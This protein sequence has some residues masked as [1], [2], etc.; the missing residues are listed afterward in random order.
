MAIQITKRIYLPTPTE[1]IRWISRAMLLNQQAERD[2]STVVAPRVS[3]ALSLTKK[4]GLMITTE[5]KGA[6]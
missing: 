1:F 3:R 5:Q 4:Q 6:N 2:T